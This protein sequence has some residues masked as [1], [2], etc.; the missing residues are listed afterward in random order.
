M[1]TTLV[2][3]KAATKTTRS[4]SIKRPRAHDNDDS[5][6]EENVPSTLF[7]DRDPDVFEDVLYFMRSNKINPRAE[8]DSVRLKMIQIEVE[9]FAYDALL[10]ACKKQLEEVA[11]AK[12]EWHSTRVDICKCIR[13]AEGEIFYLKSATLEC[14]D[15]DRNSSNAGKSY[16]LWYNLSDTDNGLGSGLHDA[17][18]PIQHCIVGG[19]KEM[20]LTTRPD[21][22]ISSRPGFEFLKLASW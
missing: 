16:K 7:V 17:W 4:E 15:E 9:F 11:K 20:N 13:L 8:Q 21:I 6:D 1:E 12:G 19:G 5:M 2:S 3:N 10:E 22:F 14:T 18:H